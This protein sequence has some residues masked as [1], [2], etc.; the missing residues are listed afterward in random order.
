MKKIGEPI[1]M[2]GNAAY[3]TIERI[4]LFDG[5]FDTAFRVTSFQ[6]APVAPTDQVE[7]IC[8]V[9]TDHPGSFSGTNWYWDNNEEIAWAGWGLPNGTYSGW[10]SN[11]DPENLVVED[12]YLQAYSTSGESGPVNYEI[13]MQKYDISDWQGALAMVRNRSQA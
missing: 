8:K 2:K 6:I 11:I 3:N 5:R 10:Y 4:T 13:T 7:I 9:S 12:L 1:T